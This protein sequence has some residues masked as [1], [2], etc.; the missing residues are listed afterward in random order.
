VNAAETEVILVTAKLVMV[1]YRNALVA[2][3]ARASRDGQCDI[4]RIAAVA[5]REV[6]G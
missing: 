5:L 6:A 3:L 4:A 2:I 1:R